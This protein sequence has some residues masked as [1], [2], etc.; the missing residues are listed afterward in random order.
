MV[1]AAP[2]G[3]A[4]AE[5]LKGGTPAPTRQVVNAA[6]PPLPAASPPAGAGGERKWARHLL[7][8]RGGRAEMTEWLVVGR[9]FFPGRDVGEKR[10]QVACFAGFRG[11]RGGWRW[12]RMVGGGRR[13][14]MPE[15]R[16]TLGTTNHHRHSR[17]ACPALDAG[18][19][20]HAAER[21]IAPW[22]VDLRVSLI[23]DGRSAPPNAVSDRG[24]VLIRRWPRLQ[25][26]EVGP[27]WIPACA[28]MTEG[29]R[30]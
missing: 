12:L 18:A 19:G 30:E 14:A 3:E 25:P 29:A 26:G 13:P 20:I 24:R 17:A 23:R 11:L 8:S 5:R 10:R 4:V 22:A 9:K 1:C 15:S 2:W 21:W 16:S 6:D 27:G 28:G 7:S